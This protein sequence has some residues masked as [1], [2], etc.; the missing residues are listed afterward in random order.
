[1]RTVEITN[2]PGV[3]RCWVARDV[4]SGESVLRLHERELLERICQ[5]LDWKIVQKDAQR[6]L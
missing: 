1:M 6:R 2:E 4:R 3:Q 5:S